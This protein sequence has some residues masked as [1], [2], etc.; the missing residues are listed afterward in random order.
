VYRLGINSTG[1]PPLHL[2]RDALASSLCADTLSTLD[3]HSQLRTTDIAAAA[4]TLLL[5]PM[6]TSHSQL[7]SEMFNK[8][9][10]TEVS[11][12]PT[13]QSSLNRRVPYGF[14]YW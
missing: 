2:L 5:L 8:L 6:L 10:P 9:N 14:C 12:V 11:T 3:E 1:A 4:L 7:V 13:Q